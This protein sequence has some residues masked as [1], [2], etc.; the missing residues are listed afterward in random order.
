MP[1]ENGE[2]A[3]RRATFIFGQIVQIGDNFGFI[4]VVIPDNSLKRVG[5]IAF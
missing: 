5:S 4:L 3:T 2:I 1:V